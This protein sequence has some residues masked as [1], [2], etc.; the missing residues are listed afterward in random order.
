MCS[1]LYVGEIKINKYLIS[2]SREYLLISNEN[3]KNNYSK[4]ISLKYSWDNDFL[5]QCYLLQMK[6]KFPQKHYWVNNQG[7]I[8]FKNID[9][10]IYINPIYTENKYMDHYIT[11][12]KYCVYFIF[13]R[14]KYRYNW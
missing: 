3:V 2:I 13:N 10:T 8:L 7:C 12:F 9:K 1:I 6:R 4:V 11:L 14:T 5:K